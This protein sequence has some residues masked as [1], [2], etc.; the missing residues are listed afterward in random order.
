M[1]AY[2]Q[3]MVLKVDDL[4]ALAMQKRTSSVDGHPLLFIH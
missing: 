2:T 1:V 4:R 3:C